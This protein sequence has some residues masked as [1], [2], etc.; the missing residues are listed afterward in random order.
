RL[1]GGFM[2]PFIADKLRKYPMDAHIP[3][4]Q[5][6]LKAGVKIAAG[7]D[8]NYGAGASTDLFSELETQVKYGMSPTQALASATIDAA[9][10]I[11]YEDQIGTLEKGKSADMIAVDGNPMEDISILRLVDFVMREGCVLTS[12]VE[13]FPA[14]SCRS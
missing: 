3:S 1:E 10:C 8:G 14:G 6:A 7:S 13:D 5:L 12:S 2:P 4:F 11:G 9:I